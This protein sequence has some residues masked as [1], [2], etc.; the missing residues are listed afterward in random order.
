MRP[1][2]ASFAAASTSAPRSLRK[3]SGSLSHVL[4]SLSAVAA[5]ATRLQV[6]AHLLISQSPNLPISR[7]AP[8]GAPVSLPLADDDEEEDEEEED[9]EDES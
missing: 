3:S 6:C 9:E 4:I 5:T 2:A 7:S 8:E 1:S